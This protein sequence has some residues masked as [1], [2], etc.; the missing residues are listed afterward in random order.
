MPYVR[1]D[2]RVKLYYEEHGEGVP[3]VLA[4]GIGGNADLWERTATRSPRITASCCGSLAVTRARAAPRIPR[5]TRSR[6]GC[7]T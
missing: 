3:L 1:T 5:G 2:D 4:Y 7:S 6:A